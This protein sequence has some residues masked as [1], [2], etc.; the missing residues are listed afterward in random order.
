MAALMSGKSYSAAAKEAGVHWR[1]VIHW[2]RDDKTFQAEYKKQ[3]IEVRDVFLTN[4]KAGLNEAADVVRKVLKSKNEG[5]RL[6]AARTLLSATAGAVMKP[7]ADQ[8]IPQVP[9][10]ALPPGT[11]IG[12]AIPPAAPVTIP[13]TS[14][15]ILPDSPLA[16][17]S[18]S[19]DVNLPADQPDYS[20]LAEP[21]DAV[22]ASR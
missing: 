2:Y 9:L 10:F 11:Q 5:R 7:D 3:C 15:T 1:T 20:A 16:L 18:S 19:N 8:A 6:A 13:A 22:K 21:M 14:V 4:I 17:S 12:F